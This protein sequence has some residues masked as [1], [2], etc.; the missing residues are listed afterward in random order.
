ML[1][2]FFDVGLS[3]LTAISLGVVGIYIWFGFQYGHWHLAASLIIIVISFARTH[4]VNEKL[5]KVRKEIDDKII[6]FKL[7]DKK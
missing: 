1:K 5:R 6:E 7:K 2:Q 3:T 4:V